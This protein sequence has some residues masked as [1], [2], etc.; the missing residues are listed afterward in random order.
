MSDF[1]KFSKPDTMIILFAFIGII[2]ILWLA[3]K[4]LLKIGNIFENLSNK[5]EERALS[6]ESLKAQQ[7]KTLRKIQKNVSKL[8]K[9]QTKK[10]YMDQ[11]QKE[12][13]ELTK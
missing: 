8:K 1:D 9:G 5:M 3:S 4:A 7:I 6:T 11:V 12:I 13:E 2:A 10:N